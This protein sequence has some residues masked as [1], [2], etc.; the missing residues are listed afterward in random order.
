MI[1]A[2]QPSTADSSMQR[3]AIARGIL[4]ALS[5]EKLTLAVPGTD[6]R[7][8]LVP[9]VPASQFAVEVG[10][11]I[12]GVIR[13]R[14][15]RIHPSGAGGR[16]IEPVYGMP[17]I[18]AGSVVHADKEHRQVT[19]N[20][21]LPMVVTALEGQDFSFLRPGAFVTFYVQEGSMFV[22]VGF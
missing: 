4:A 13:S 9:A 2:M 14:A 6:Y 7:I 22:P 11:R 17:R 20:V 3:E 12:K 5:D 19:V 16:W 21:A 10:R 18:V 1:S 15:L 8:D